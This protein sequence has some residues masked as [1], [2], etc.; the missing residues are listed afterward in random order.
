MV[1]LS[2]DFFKKKIKNFK[3][4]TFRN[5]IRVTNSLD[6][7]LV[8]NHFP[9]HHGLCHLRSH[10]VMF[11][12]SLIWVHLVCKISYLLSKYFANNMDPDQTG[13]SQVWVG[14]MFRTPINSGGIGV[15]VH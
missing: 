9:A 4:E 1:F 13:S 8:F 14:D 12:N 2:A 6:P 5:T 10:L 15:K 11:F 7:E 3:K